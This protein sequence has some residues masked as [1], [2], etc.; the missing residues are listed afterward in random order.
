MWDPVRKSPRFRAVLEKQ[1]LL[2]EYDKTW[3]YIEQSMAREGAK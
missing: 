2:G 3:R 1:G